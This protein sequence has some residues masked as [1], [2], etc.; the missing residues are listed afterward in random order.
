MKSTST[1]PDGQMHTASRGSSSPFSPLR[2]AMKAL[3]DRLNQMGTAIALGEAGDLDGA[4]VWREQHDA[5]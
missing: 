2:N 1:L 4:H 5:K 3:Y